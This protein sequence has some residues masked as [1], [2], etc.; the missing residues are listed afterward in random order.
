MTDSETDSEDLFSEQTCLEQIPESPAKTVEISGKTL[1]VFTYVQNPNAIQ[2]DYT[3]SQIWAG[4]RAL[5][6]Y[7]SF[8]FSTE[9]LV[10][11]LTVL[12]LGAGTGLP[13]TISYF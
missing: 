11:N 8:L 3:G 12:E 10:T 4:G 5:A 1:K 9:K 7:V 6:E 2:S 13:G